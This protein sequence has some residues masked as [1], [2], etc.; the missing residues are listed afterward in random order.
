MATAENALDWGPRRKSPILS[1]FWQFCWR[2]FLRA[3]CL[4]ERT[5]RFEADQLISVGIPSRF[6]QFGRRWNS[7]RDIEIEMCTSE[8]VRC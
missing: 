2:R 6:P 7:R 3:K 1:S 4:G 8:P 5:S